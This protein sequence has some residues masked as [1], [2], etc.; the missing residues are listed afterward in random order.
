MKQLI[1]CV[2]NFSE[3]RDMNII[4]QIT[5]QIE[6]VEGVK[7][8]DVDPGATTNRT[9]VT[10]V[11]TPDEV[12]EAAFR[13][14]K[15]ASEIIDM[16]KH[17]GEHP[18][19]GATDV[20]PLVPV[21]NITMEETAGYA[22]KLAKRI[23]EELK[24]PIYCYENA[25]FDEKRRNLAYCRQ[26][27]YEALN[28]KLNKPEW[29]PDFGPSGFNDHV[30][31]TGAT[32][33]GARDFL[34]AFNVNLNT[35]STRRANAIA[36]DVRE[37]GRKKRE[38]DPVTGPVVKDENGKD[39]WIPGSLKCVKGMGWFIDEFGIAQIS[40][41][42][43]NISVTPV[44]VAFDEVYK[45]AAERGIRVTGSELVGLIPLNAMLDA[46]KHYL[47]MQRRSLGVSDKELI[48]IAV[49]SMG[50]DDLYKF[51]PDEK[52]IEYVLAKADKSKKLVDMTLTGFMNETASES[53]APGGGS[54]AAYMGALGAALGTMVANLSSHKRGWDDKWE[55][56]SNWAEK[57]KAYHDKLNFL[58]DEDT[59][60][61]NKIMDAF[62]L[63][64]KTDAEKAARKQA[65]QDATKYAI[66]IPFLV[67]ET[68]CNS[69][70]VMKAM[71]EYG[72]QTSI[73]DAGVGAIA[74]R[75]AVLGAFL[76]VK[77]NAKDLED[78]VYVD[79]IIEKG[80]AVS[81]NSSGEIET[82]ECEEDLEKEELRKKLL[83]L[84]PPMKE[85]GI[86]KCL[87]KP[88]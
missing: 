63:P 5:D 20:C 31:K 8:L 7:L 36:F 34:V 76:N 9:V 59:R 13:A 84:S 50:L 23:G 48:K 37:K 78:K 19:M 39:V 18:R 49:K 32:A 65:I 74:A 29:K 16:R 53:P 12:L 10:I 45:K 81:W 17:K 47:R 67:M 40:M 43:T 51:E 11:G 24:I 46:G 3:G 87:E 15:K 55:E 25:A 79:N 44:H 54:I 27:E 28:D 85:W 88:E 6:T 64:K 73:S 60:A 42:L 71:V 22:R 41:N 35:T 62:G 26:G 1:E 66:E 82:G 77:I 14:V 69:M 38:G 57:G 70:E 68:A 33:V 2:P 58:V 30:A 72:L 21:A 80:K 86:A 52:I 4:R 75:G 56:Y 61:F 83:A